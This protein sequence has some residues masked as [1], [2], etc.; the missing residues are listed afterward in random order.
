MVNGCHPSQEIAD[1]V[2]GAPSAVSSEPDLDETRRI[3]LDKMSVGTASQAPEQP[4]H[5]LARS[6]TDI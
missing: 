1:H 6:G 3:Q 2:E 5:H 4:A